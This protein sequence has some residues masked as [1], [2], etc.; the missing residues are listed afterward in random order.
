MKLSIIIP[1]YKALK[2]TKE[3]MKV[4][5]PQLTKDVE[6]II[7]DDGCNE[8]ELD[9]FKAKVI[10]LDHNSG[11]AS[12]PRNVG[13]DNSTGEYLVFVDA[14]DMVTDDFI[15]TLLDKIKKENFDYC[16]FSWHYNGEDIIIED[17]PPIWNTSACNCIYKRTLIGNERFNPDIRIGEDGE[18]NSRVRKGKKANITKVLYYYNTTNEQSVTYNARGWK[19]IKHTNV[20]YANDLHMIGGVE[21]Y[22][23]EMVKKYHNLD[24]CV[25]YKTADK[26]QLQRLK[27]LV[28]VYRVD[29]TTKIF[30]DRAI[31]NYD[32]SIIDQIDKNI[33]KENLKPGDKKGIYQ[34]IHGDYSNPHYQALGIPIP[35]DDRL[36]GYITITHYSEKSF[37][38]LTGIK[39]E[40]SYNPLSV[41][42][43]EKPI[44][45]MSAL[46]LRPEKG[47]ERMKLLI[48]AL[49]KK[50]V[51]YLWYIFAD[52]QFDVDDSHLVY[53]KPRLDLGYFMEQADYLVQLSDT[54]C[55]SYSVNE[56]LFRNKPVIVTPLPYLE[57]IGVKDGKNAYIMEFDCSNVDEIAEKITKIPK[58][59]Y[60]RF[61]DSYD[62]FLIKS[63]STYEYVPDRKYLVRAN[64]QWLMDSLIDT[65]LG[66]IPQE[67][68]EYE[69]TEERLEVLLGNNPYKNKYVD[70]VKEIK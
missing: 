20:L 23:Y 9:K 49:N 27:K 4:L 26:N 28:P 45:L 59:E 3:L 39:P 10:H 6:I 19:A 58:F 35:T 37:E 44:I 14:D 65:D 5:E 62:K 24:I 8:S 51:N 70:V 66:F 13:I 40:F 31:I 33:W 29:E 2:Y 1:Y 38:K 15:K 12:T 25:C 52:E 34:T 18:F 47:T 67:G 55:C 41:E 54:E 56:M 50:G 7:V 61:T 48:N 46:R 11:S 64:K 16:L 57:E 30:C 60:K 68:Y 36:K 53:I 43:G 17:E 42:S 63:K 69:V 22:L 32:T 21:T